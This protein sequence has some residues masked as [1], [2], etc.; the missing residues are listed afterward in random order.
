M[1]SAG[2]S[3]SK[4]AAITDLARKVE[5]GTVPCTTSTR[6]QTT[7]WWRAWSR[8]GASAAGPPRCSSCSSSGGSMSGPS[9]TTACAKAGRSPTGY[10]T[11]S[12]PAPSRL[13][14]I[15]FARFGP[16]QPGTAGEPSTPFFRPSDRIS[17]AG[18]RS[19]VG[20]RKAVEAGP[21]PAG[22]RLR[23]L[24]VEAHFDRM[25][26][27]PRWR[28]ARARQRAVARRHPQLPFDEVEPGHHF[29]HRMF[30]L[31]A[32][33]DLHEI[34]AVIGSGR[35]RPPCLSAPPAHPC[36]STMNSTVPALT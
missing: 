16:L 5:D 25:S 15:A 11:C 32:R 10:P 23:I 18:A 7:S 2:L 1:R 8:C 6:C 31:Q 34:E 17:G 20:R 19:R 36:A 4:A 9:T 29:G 12:A 35:Y 3:G 14:A 30:D 26:V 13:R 27:W 22:S 24:G 21:T 28:P 33:V